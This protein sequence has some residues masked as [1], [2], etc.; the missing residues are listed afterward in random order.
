MTHGL[1]PEPTPSA[2]ILL[3][4]KGDA[5]IVRLKS[6]AAARSMV[7]N[8]N[9]KTSADL[10]LGCFYEL[11]RAAPPKK[12]FLSA[13][14]GG[15]AGNMKSVIDGL[16]FSRGRGGPR[17]EQ[18]QQGCYTAPPYVWHTGDDRSGR[19][20]DGE[21][22]LIN[23]AGCSE[24]KRI[25]IYAFIYEG[26]PQWSR[27]DGVVT[28]SIPGSPDVVVEM[29]RQSSRKAFCAVAGLDFLEDSVRVTKL[30]TFHDGHADCDRA[31]RWGLG[32]RSGA[33]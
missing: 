5:E 21:S 26:A 22:I 23:P 15:G 28:V 14:L 17:D 20:T 31:Y 8:L 13:L 11:K 7:V 1:K 30:V 33:K 25:T 18:T 10:D 29:G 27:T 12:G 32:W 6:K 19:S 2:P 16:Q 3:K 24:L 9:W 4:K